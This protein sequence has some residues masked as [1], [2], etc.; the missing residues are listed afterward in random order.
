MKRTSFGESSTEEREN[1]WKF[2]K[3]LP[4]AT[5]LP[6]ITT[7]SKYVVKLVDTFRSIVSYARNRRSTFVLAIYEKIFRRSALIFKL[8]P[9]GLVVLM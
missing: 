7:I 8:L 9:L 6:T 2:E 4:F 5:N 1:R 3:K